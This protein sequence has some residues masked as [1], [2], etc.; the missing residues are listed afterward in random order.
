MIWLILYFNFVFHAS[1]KQS[2][3]IVAYSIIE[4]VFISFDDDGDGWMSGE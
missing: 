2:F 1:P 3:Y 4:W